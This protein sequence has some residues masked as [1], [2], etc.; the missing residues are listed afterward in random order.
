M[1]WAFYTVSRPVEKQSEGTR[2]KKRAKKVGPPFY[3]AFQLISSDINGKMPFD[4][5]PIGYF[6]G[7]G[8][9]DCGNLRSVQFLR[10]EHRTFPL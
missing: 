4:N 3:V 5:P 10:T 7:L 8:I 6:R 2:K 1:E 9:W